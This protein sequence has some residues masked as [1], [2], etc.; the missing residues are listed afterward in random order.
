MTND[1]G[2]WLQFAW[3]VVRGKLMDSLSALNN[4]VNPSESIG[5]LEQNPATL[6]SSLYAVSEGPRIR[7]LWRSFQWLKK[8]ASILCIVSLYMYY[9]ITLSIIL[10]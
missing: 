7:L 10:L 2:V 8:E 4:R 9:T 5:K 6:P 1:D 3:D